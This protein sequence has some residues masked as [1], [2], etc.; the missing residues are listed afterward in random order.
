MFEG[1]QIAAELVEERRL[2]GFYEPKLPSKGFVEQKNV[3]RIEI[4]AKDDDG[5]WEEFKT[6]YEKNYQS[7][8]EEAKRK[9]IFIDKKHYIESENTK[10]KRYPLRFMPWSDETDDEF[11]KK[12]LMYRPFMNNHNS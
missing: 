2:M 1:L 9:A 8:E 12:R 3:Q 10:R 7:D 6:K 4:L 11:A 5:A